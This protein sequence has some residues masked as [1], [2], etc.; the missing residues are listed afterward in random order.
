MVVAL[1]AGL[2]IGGGGVGLGWMLSGDKANTAQ[3]DAHSACGIFNNLQLSA[4][5]DLTTRLRTTAAAILAEAANADD[6]R[7]RQLRDALH[8][9]SD[10]IALGNP[11]P[12]AADTI[13]KMVNSVKTACAGV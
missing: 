11:P 4:D 1:V 7:Y 12:T 2:V 10:F 8:E 3:N 5:S 6:P 13:D 9:L